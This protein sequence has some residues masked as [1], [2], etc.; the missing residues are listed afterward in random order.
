MIFA[1]RAEAGR[2]LAWRLEKYANRHDVVVLGIPRGG[3]PVAA[4]VAEALRAPLDVF[5]VLKLG[6]P[7]HEELAFGA[8]SSGSVRV[9]NRQILRTLSIRSS[10]VE[11]ITARAEE[12]LKRGE[13]AY[14]GDQG[15]L[16][17]A[18]KTVILVDDGVA[19]GTSLL[20]GIRALR[21]LRPAKI[22]VA[23]PV[24][25]APVSKRLAYEVDEMVCVVT[26][27]PFG[28]IGQFYDDFSQVEDKEVVQLLARYQRAESA[29]AA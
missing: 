25:P 2:S 16:S 10:E 1:N 23:V 29:T 17:V 21:Q 12:E 20:A 7:G 13:A 6:V 9:P 22:V 14:R 4:E 3:I 11:G 18:G 8:I 24:A 27:E 26:P 5:L 28:A 19:T 15:P